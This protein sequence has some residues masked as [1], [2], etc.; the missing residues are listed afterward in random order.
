ME[1]VVKV[2]L[3]CPCRDELITIPLSD[4]L[5]SKL[6]EYCADKL[7]EMHPSWREDKDMASYLWRKM[8]NFEVYP[9]PTESE[10]EGSD[11]VA[12]EQYVKQ[13]GPFGGI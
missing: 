4:E 8:W 13:D 6:H 1:W 9:R 5:V 12:F 3:E 11:S 7:I 10:Q 2:L